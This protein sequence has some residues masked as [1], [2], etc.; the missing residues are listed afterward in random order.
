MF[1][2]RDWRER[3]LGPL[4]QMWT[5]RLEGA[6]RVP[7]F[8]EIDHETSVAGRLRVRQPRQEGPTPFTSAWNQ[9]PQELI[10]RRP[11]LQLPDWLPGERTM[12]AFFV[13]V[14]TLTISLLAAG[15][16]DQ[17][18]LGAQSPMM[19]AP[20]P[21]GEVALVQTSP[22]ATSSAKSPTDAGADDEVSVADEPAADQAAVQESAP[23]GATVEATAAFAPMPAIGAANAESYDPQVDGLLPHNRIVA[24]YG[25]PHDE[26]M[27]ILGEYPMEEVHRLLM[28]EVERY[29]I[30][31]PTRPV[32]PTFEI[33]ATV[34]QR[35]PGADGTYLLDTDIKTLTEWVNYAADH[36]M[37][38]IL[39][40][41]VGR[42]SVAM[43]FEKVRSL[44]LR[45]NVHLAIDPEFAVV[46]GQTPGLHIGSV[47]AES[48]RYAQEELAAMVEA[49]GLPPKMLIV[50]QFREDMIKEKETLGPIPG[51]QLVIDADGFGDPDLKK[52]VYNILVRDEP[53]EFAGIKLFYKQDK[54]LLEPGEVTG[55]NPSPDVVIIQ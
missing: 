52:S 12:S 6:S 47:W 9:A 39:D 46:E 35:V 24:Y 13:L 51:V 7:L 49:N 22:E 2:A 28:E 34:A 20:G 14:L 4:P 11:A 30:A 29:E 33:I 21:E 50:H 27:G 48:I 19:S 55:L 45:P 37:H 15:R 5:A 38:V 10:V 3:F 42:S 23:P 36:D 44:L 17:S 32:I 31:D 18:L 43:E 54:P 26:N 40:V 16:T 8:L 1:V 41:Q 53:V 25:H